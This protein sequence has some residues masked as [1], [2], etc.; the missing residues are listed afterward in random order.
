M[1]LSKR[2]LDGALGIGL[3][4]GRGNASIGKSLSNSQITQPYTI[5]LESTRKTY[6]VS[7][8]PLEQIN[9]LLEIITDFLLRLIAS[10]ATRLNSVNAS[11]VLAPLVFPEGLVVTINVDPVLVHVRDQIGAVLCLQDLGDVGVCARGV[12]VGLVCAVA[13]VRPDIEISVHS[14]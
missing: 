9:G 4:V 1:H 2:S 6:L 11:T 8:K 12:A 13:V 3:G 5:K 10:I 7:I 14:P